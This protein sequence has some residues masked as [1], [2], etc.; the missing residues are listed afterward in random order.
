MQ[1]RYRSL[2]HWRGAAAL[3]VL[4]FHG[5]NSWLGEHPDKLPHALVLLLAHGWLGVPVFFVISGYCIA[6]RL[7]RDF[8]TGQGAGRFLLDRGMRIFPAYWCALALTVAIDLAALPFD[9]AAL[10]SA[11]SAWGAL[12]GSAG[13]LMAN[14]FFLE[15]WTGHDPR[16]IV[17]WTLLYEVCFYAVAGIT[18][19]LMN[20]WR[21]P[22]PA[23]IM[24]AGCLLAAA[25]TSR[26]EIVP[27]DLL[28]EFILGTLV[29]LGLH[30]CP[31]PTAGRAG[32]TAGALGLCWIAT[33]IL[34]THNPLSFH[35]AAGTASALVLLRPLD[36]RLAGAPWLRWL[37]S[38]GLISYSLYLVHVPVVG[39]FRNLAF[40]GT[41]PA[42]AWAWLA[43]LV[44]CGLAVL[45]AMLFHRAI[46]SRLERLRRR[47]FSPGP[48]LTPA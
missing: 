2:D 23:G 24:A 33:P 3:W 1:P 27:L 9:H 32:L 16:V 4:L 28:P 14:L 5:F 40:H 11:P 47:L 8:G 26:A 18:L 21:S 29:W 7:A 46:E 34:G 38:A 13:E 30:R 31:L 20:R 25:L 39:K 22:W 36:D 45:A 48:P 10:F 12:P 37:G 41:D 17:S 35:F 15:R 44:G 19:G 43:P 6:E 42:G